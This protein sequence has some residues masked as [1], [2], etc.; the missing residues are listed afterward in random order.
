MTREEFARRWLGA[1]AAPPQ[2]APPRWRASRLTDAP[3][4]TFREQ[5]PK[6]SR[7]VRTGRFLKRWATAT[8]AASILFVGMAMLLVKL[9]PYVTDYA[10]TYLTY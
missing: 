6:P 7:L 8:G 3:S 10:A 2:D 1:P 4:R 9:A 5:A